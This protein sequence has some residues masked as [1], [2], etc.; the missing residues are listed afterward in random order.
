MFVVQAAM[1]FSKFANKQLF[2]GDAS[3]WV[4]GPVTWRSPGGRYTNPI[5]S[6]ADRALHCTALHWFARPTSR[7]GSRVQGE[8]ATQGLL[9]AA[10]RCPGVPCPAWRVGTPPLGQYQH[11]PTA[12][13]GG[14]RR[15]RGGTPDCGIITGLSTLNGTRWTHGGVS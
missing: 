5:H 6:A 12:A 14:P 7:P 1:C 9:S 2:L 15:T 10:P 11:S 4:G 8:A 3:C 13:H